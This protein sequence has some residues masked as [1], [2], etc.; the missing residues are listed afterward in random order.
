MQIN[1]HK[2]RL[3]DNQDEESKAEADSPTD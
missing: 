2:K 1:T 3:F